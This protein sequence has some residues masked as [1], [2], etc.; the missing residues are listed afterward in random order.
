MH[1]LLSNDIM[2]LV[3][4]GLHWSNC[5]VYLDDVIVVGKS[6]SDHMA[7]L[8]QVLSRF[9]DANL[10]LK[11]SKCHFLHTQVRFLGHMVSKDGILPDPSNTTRVYLPGQLPI[12][13]L[14]YGHSLVFVHTTAD[15]CPVLPQSP[16]P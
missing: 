12:M 16:V 11:P 3:L 4:R 9:R 7:N 6:F 15:L 14:K 10:K 2:E 8:E 5:L 13:P 1:P